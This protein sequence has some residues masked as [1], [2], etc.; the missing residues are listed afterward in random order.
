MKLTSEFLTILP[1][2][3]LLFPGISWSAQNII[4]ANPALDTA[5]LFLLDKYSENQDKLISFSAKYEETYVGEHNDSTSRE[6]PAKY[7]RN[8]ISECWYDKG[9][10]K[11]RE[12]QWGNIYRSASEYCPKEKASYRN[13]IYDGKL[14]YQYFADAK[15]II[16][17]KQ[18]TYISPHPTLINTRG[19]QF[20][21]PGVLMGYMEGDFEERID[22]ILRNAKSLKLREK[23]EL[24]N[25]SSCYAIEGITRKGKYTVWLDPDHGY[26]IAQAVVERG[27][28]D[29]YFYNQ[30]ALT[31]KTR[32]ELAI[33]DIRFKKFDTLWVPIELTVKYRQYY[34]TGS[35]KYT[36]HHKNTEF[37]LNPDLTNAFVPDPIPDGTKL[38]ISESTKKVPKG[39]YIWK[40][41]RPCDKTG[42][43]LDFNE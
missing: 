11:L 2:I 31:T 39:D 28:G 15:N 21:R 26:N 43:P 16:H 24:I 38:I 35:W 22:S 33:Q 9:K 29:I 12:F 17:Q 6:A 42:T 30:P 25:G 20:R 8:Q 34:T 32:V 19:L 18:Y 7:N 10:F 36:I 3:F 5:A 41:G 40:N 37:I 14:W 27:A 23:P 1:I 4:P 13:I